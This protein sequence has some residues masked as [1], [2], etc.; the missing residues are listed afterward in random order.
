MFGAS[1]ELTQ[2]PH[3]QGVNLG[4]PGEPDPHWALLGDELGEPDPQ[5][6][7]NHG[8]DRLCRKKNWFQ[9]LIKCPALPNHQ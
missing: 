3:F 7:C 8:E 6:E 4:E 5:G 2:G 1:S 9:G